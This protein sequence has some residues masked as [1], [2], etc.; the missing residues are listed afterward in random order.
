[1]AAIARSAGNR[2]LRLVLVGG[3]SLALAGCDKCSMPTWRHDTVPNSCHE[4][5]PPK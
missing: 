3:L 5:A 2:L 1:M 4:D